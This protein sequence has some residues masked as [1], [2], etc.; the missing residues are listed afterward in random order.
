MMVHSPSGHWYYLET[1]REQFEHR[2]KYQAETNIGI[3]TS[4]ANLLQ[5]HKSSIRTSPQ[6][7][8]SVTGWN[9]IPNKIQRAEIILSDIC[10]KLSSK[11]QSGFLFWV[12]NVHDMRIQSQLGTRKDIKWTWHVIFWSYKQNA[13]CIWSTIVAALNNVA[14]LNL[15]AE[16]GSLLRILVIHFLKWSS[17]LSPSWNHTLPSQQMAY[18]VTT[19]PEVICC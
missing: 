18:P 7:R 5:F 13:L 6:S 11:P 19:L 4:N 15:Q 3:A 17:F 16:A 12:L 9:S 8:L 2:A 14:V 10:E 1:Y